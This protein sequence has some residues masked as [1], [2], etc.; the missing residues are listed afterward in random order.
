[1]FERQVLTQITPFLSTHDIVLL[2]GARQVGKTTL[3]KIIQEKYISQPF[4][5][6]DLEEEGDLEALNQSPKLFIDYL[7]TYKARDGKQN[8]VIFIDE[9]QYLDNPTSLLKYIYDHYEMIKFIISGSST[10]EIRGKLKDSLAGRMMKFEIFPLSFEEFLIFK[11]KENLANLIGKPVALKSVNDELSF[12][13]KEFLLFGGYPK[14]VLTD[15]EEVKKAYLQQLYDTYIQKDI[16][17]IGKI[18]DIEKFNNLLKLLAEQAGNLVNISELSSIIGINMPTLKERL[19]LLENTFV[20]KLI[21][22]FSKNIRWEL[23]KMPKVYFIDNWLRNCCEKKFE[24]TGNGFENSFF[25]YI[26]NGYKADEIRFY[27]TKDKQEVDFVLDGKPYELKLKYTGKR[28]SALGLFQERYG[29]QGEVVSLEKSEGA[30][31]P[32]EV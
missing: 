25:A 27:R 22:P 13:Y 15:W 6:F 2:Y 1:M 26:N 20:I 17:D 18:G 4:F 9:I 8:I 19:F 29:Q 24:I 11:G 31:C 7:K 21:K 3:M 30:K 23:A 32:W 16:K 28:L 5:S 14:V 10:L 12:Y